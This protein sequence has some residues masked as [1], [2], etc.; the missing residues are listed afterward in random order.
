MES[1]SFPQKR[2]A[3]LDYIGD[4]QKTKAQVVNK[5]QVWY[6]NNQSYNIGNVLSR[7]VELE[8]LKVDEKGIYTLPE[9]EEAAPAEEENQISLF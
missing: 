6:L 3:I 1:L 8:L 5:F 4:G 7:M 9:Q 2:R